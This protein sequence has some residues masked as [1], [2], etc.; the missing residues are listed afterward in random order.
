LSLFCCGIVFL[1]EYF[2][3]APFYDFIPF[4]T[5]FFYQ[6][7]EQALLLFFIL[8]SVFGFSRS[9]SGQIWKK[10]NNVNQQLNQKT[11]ELEKLNNVLE[12][13]VQE[14]TK[15]LEEAKNILEVKVV[16]RTKELKELSDHLEMDVQNRTKELQQKIEELEKFN[17]LTIGRELKMVELKKEIE[18]L[19]I[20]LKKYQK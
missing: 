20:E 18:K 13:K 15:E 4:L 14:R 7:K 11:E 10:F 1:W 16:A 19:K 5:G 17:K 12:K 2:G 8:S 3:I 9:F 6:K